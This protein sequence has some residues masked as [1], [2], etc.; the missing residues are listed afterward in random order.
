MAVCRAASDRAGLANKRELI[1]TAKKTKRNASARS[2]RASSAGQA[3]VSPPAPPPKPSSAQS[4]LTAAGQVM[5]ERGRQYDLPGGE[6]SM[7][8]TVQA[9]NAI[10]RR[11]LSASD[12]WL[13]MLLL[14]QARLFQCPGLH[15]DSA[16]DAVAYASLLAEARAQEGAPK[17]TQVSKTGEGVS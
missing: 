7:A 9:F 6:R 4:F 13:L 5:A 16:M 15:Y 14:K 3:A 1:V 12:G 2:N 17:E 8:R 11:E 10:T